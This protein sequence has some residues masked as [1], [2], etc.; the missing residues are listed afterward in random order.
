[1]ETGRND[2][3]PCGSGRKYKQCCLP[4]ERGAASGDVIPLH[5]GAAALR[6]R[7]RSAAAARAVWEIDAVPLMIR[8]EEP[9]AQ[10]PVL[11]LV[12]AGDIIV[13]QDIR[14]RLAGETTSVAAA[15]E[16]A[17]VA[18]ARSAGVFPER[19]RVRHAEVAE[20]LRPLL[21]ARDVA[22][23]HGDVPQ[24]V[25]AARGA[26]HAMDAYDGWP[27]ACRV[28]SWSAWELAPS[29]VGELFAAAAEF[30]ERAPWRSV[31]NLQAPRALLPSGREW[32]CCVLGNAGEEFGLALYSE[33]A[34][35]FDAMASGSPGGAFGGVR[36]RIVSLSFDT[37]EDA[38]RLAVAEAKRHGW[39]F[40]GGRAF[41]S[42]MTVNTP[43]GGVS[44]ADAGDLVALLR[45]VPA[46]VQ[47]HRRAL[48]EEIRTGQ[49]LAALEWR[50]APSGV[51]FRYA[52]EAAHYLARASQP[53]VP[54]GGGMS[55]DDLAAAIREA[56]AEVG[57]DAT[58]AELMA[59]VNARL[60]QVVARYNEA[61]Q[62]DLG[63]LSPAQTRRLLEPDWED[64]AGAIRLRRDLPFDELA[65]SALLFNARTLLA[66]AI[67]SDG[68]G[69]TEA[70]N[71]KLD[72]VA[73]LLDRLRLEPE[74]VEFLRE[75]S[76]RIREQDV[77]ELHEVRVICELAG[78]L[79]KRRQR[80]EPTKRARALLDERRAGELFELLF[81]TYFRKYDLEYRDGFE[82]RELQTQAAYTLYRLPIVAQHWRGP[83]DLIDD[84]V[85]PYALESSRDGEYAYVPLVLRVLDPLVTFGL[86]ARRAPARRFRELSAAR[87]RVSP[88]FARFVSWEW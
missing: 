7:V 10:R 42:L 50:D 62:P 38:G 52:S 70:G 66:L 28:D 19:V 68:L 67:E 27:P 79:R 59:A 74:N 1:M 11:V 17:V 34:D 18:A 56:S 64:P 12:M 88:L 23:E 2:P 4:R 86:L 44:R 77:W 76:K 14:G 72:V 39:R 51:T 71:L 81:R 85:L 24:L 35:L 16:R 48:H 26:M 40:A 43:G 13:H 55:H 57:E 60:E 41:P 5:G 15:L 47:A 20:T 6:A 3:C 32:T 8:F 49:P 25:E 45:A 31:R 46:F 65:G 53:E 87:Y 33:A 78:L 75:R 9:E 36:G 69:A 82:W 80:F 61:P 73:T 83:R 58:E 29:L 30:H 54:L 37:A 22:V 63:G 21:R 84:V